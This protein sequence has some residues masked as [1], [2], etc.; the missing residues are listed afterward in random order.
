MLASYIP[1]E[2]SVVISQAST[3]ISERLVMFMEDTFVAVEHTADSWTTYNGVD[4]DKAGSTRVH[5]SSKA[6][7]IT[8][9]LQQTSPSN[10]VLQAIFDRDNTQYDG[11][12]SIIVKDGSGR[13]IHHAKE[14]YIGKRPTQTFG[15]GMNGI[16]WVIMSGDLAKSIGGNSKVEQ[17]TADS[18]A[19]AGGS[20]SSEWIL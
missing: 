8:V 11:V 14:A 18:V 3:G 16:E 4:S 6:G 9:S 2:V 17:S 10:D 20:I 5:N 7:T 15:S 12:F 13:S 19:K 1:T